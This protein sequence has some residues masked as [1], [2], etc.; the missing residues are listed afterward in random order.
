MLAQS[1]SIKRRVPYLVILIC[2]ITNL[3]GVKQEFR[4]MDSFSLWL[5]FDFI[6]SWKLFLEL[7]MQLG[8]DIF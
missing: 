1:D 8:D 2:N 7:R 6:K 5:S 3:E 4:Y